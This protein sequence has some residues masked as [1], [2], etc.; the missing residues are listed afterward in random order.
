MLKDILHTAK[1]TIGEGDQSFTVRALTLADIA[2][3]QTRHVDALTGMLESAAPGDMLA[4]WPAACA[5]IIAL[6]AGE[7]DAETEAGS[8]PIGVQIA[9]IESIWRLS[10]IDEV[11]LGKL[12]GRIAKMMHQIAAT[13]S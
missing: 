8:L 5:A 11:A 6:A 4:R 3:L 12:A 10:R 9:A 1:E 13:A 7:P 2:A